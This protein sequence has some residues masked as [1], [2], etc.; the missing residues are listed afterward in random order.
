MSYSCEICGK[1][2]TILEHKRIRNEV[3]LSYSYLTCPHHT[4]AER[5]RYHR[6]KA[7]LEAAE[8]VAEKQVRYQHK[9]MELGRR[10]FQKDIIKLLREKADE[11]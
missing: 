7:F 11:E 4:D 6:K 9:F 10:M 8:M 5:A 2:Y 1:S 3:P